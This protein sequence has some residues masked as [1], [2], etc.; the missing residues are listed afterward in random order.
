[1]NRDLMPGSLG[2]GL[3]VFP[4]QVCSV[5]NPEDESFFCPVLLQ[6]SSH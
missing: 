1:M 3:G 5:A 4:G 6:V 2:P